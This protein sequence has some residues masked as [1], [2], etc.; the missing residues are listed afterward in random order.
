MNSEFEGFTL[1][2]AE[3]DDK[4]RKSL[5]LLLEIEFKVIPVVDGYQLYLAAKNYTGKLEKLI[6]VSDTDMPELQGDLACKRLLKED[7]KYKKVIMIGMSMESD[8]EKYWKGIG[9][10]DSFINK[11]PDQ[12]DLAEIVLNRIRTIIK[13]PAIYLLKDGYRRNI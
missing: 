9:V 6:I 12:N 10:K 4:I 1:I 2:L 11:K 8:N 13:N 3:D 5:F 7:E